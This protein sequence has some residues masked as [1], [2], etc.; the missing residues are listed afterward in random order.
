[1]ALVTVGDANKAVA[2]GNDGEIEVGKGGETEGGGGVAVGENE[3]VAELKEE[4][5]G[6]VTVVERDEGWVGDERAP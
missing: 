2:E 5:G 1:M 4:K 6:G 3:A